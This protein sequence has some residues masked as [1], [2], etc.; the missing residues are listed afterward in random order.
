MD[1]KKRR[2]TE[3]ARARRF[4]RLAFSICIFLV[5]LA[6]IIAFIIPRLL[7]ENNI[8]TDLIQQTV[9]G[10]Q[11]GQNTAEDI[12]PQAASAVNTIP[13]ASAGEQPSVSGSSDQSTLASETETDTEAVMETEQ[14]EAALPSDMVTEAVAHADL[15]AAG[16][17]YDGAIA[18]LEEM[19][20]TADHAVQEA[21]A[22]YQEIKESC[23]AVDVSTVPHIFYH[24]LVNEPEIAFN[25][26][27]LGQFAAD[28]MNAWMTTVEE[29]DKITQQLYDN[30]YVYVRL[31]DLVVETRDADGNSH[32]APRTD[33]MLPPGKKAI[34]LSID[35]LSYYH[36][37]ES[38][39]FPDKLVL[40]E[41]GLVKCHYIQKDGTESIGDY[42]VVPR[43]N[44]FLE[45]HPDGAYKG[46]RGLIALTGYNG[47]FGYRTDIDYENRE[48]LMSD[49]E[50]WLEEHPDY[51]RQ[52]EIAQA[53]IIADALKE[54]GWEFASHTW[55]HLSVTARSVEELAADNDKWV[56]N[57]QNIVG[58]TD[59]IIFAHGNDI[60][61]WMPYSEDNEKY[62]LYKNAGYNFFCNVDGSAPYWVQINDTNVRQGRID[63]DGYMLYQSSIGETTTLDHLV[64][65]SEIFDSRRP[66]PVVAN[67]E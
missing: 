9:T 10:V 33:L 40:D 22:R 62:M 5:I 53:V 66:T 35:D 44:S 4:R 65:A 2:R 64:T 60:G 42:D 24:S 52:E 37:Y 41:N 19:N 54:E 26:D 8:I 17:D 63:L 7:P 29:F 61:D 57:V 11:S 32:F 16:Y 30:G 39:S 48:K 55:G 58:E 25:A 15:L 49:Q 31:R 3:R 12:Q 34:V 47:V 38:A 13:D 21:I 46:A 14:A 56:A 27:I 50:K 59:T 6:A 36:S 51:N 18:Y 1:T 67:G 28:G 43:L 45:Q 20:L 23:V